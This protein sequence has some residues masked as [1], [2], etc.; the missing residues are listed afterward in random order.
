MEFAGFLFR[1]GY[2]NPGCGPARR[3]VPL[4]YVPAYPLPYRRKRNAADGSP[5]PTIRR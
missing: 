3:L 1:T 2:V 4:A 5:P